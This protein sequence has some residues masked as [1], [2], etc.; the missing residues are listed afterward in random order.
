M[1]WILCAFTSNICENA[2]VSFAMSVSQSVLSLPS[3]N[4]STN[5]QIFMKHDSGVLLKSFDTLEYLLKSDKDNGILLKDL[6]RFIR[7]KVSLKERVQNR[8]PMQHSGW[9]S[10]TYPPP[11]QAS[12][13]ITHDDAITPATP[14]KQAL[15]TPHNFDITASIRDSKGHWYQIKCYWTSY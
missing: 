2:P 13:V 12:V 14:P 1:V 7:V 8:M 11:T 9:F 5:E 6:L 15:L 4:S 10:A 3:C